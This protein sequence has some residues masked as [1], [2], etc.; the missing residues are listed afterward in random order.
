MP[1]AGCEPQVVDADF[2]LMMTGYRQDPALFK[3]LGVKLEGTGQPS[4]VRR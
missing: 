3:M 4:R 2:V 1:L